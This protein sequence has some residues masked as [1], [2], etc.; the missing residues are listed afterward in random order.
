MLAI[1]LNVGILLA[2]VT[3]AYLPYTVVP[4]VLIVFPVVFFVAML[5]LPETPRHLI[6]HGHPEVRIDY[7]YSCANMLEFVKIF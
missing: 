3:G 7:T 4:G 2:Y 6:T 5:L 1:F